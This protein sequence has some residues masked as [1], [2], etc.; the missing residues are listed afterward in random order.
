MGLQ[1]HEAVDDM[2]AGFLEHAR[3]MD[4]V[5]LVETGLQLHE[6]DHLLAVL[7][8]VDER[9]DDGGV[10]AGAVERHLDGQHQRVGRGS[11]DE[12]DDTVE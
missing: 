6:G 7:R 1:S 9:L 10:A 12:L 4:I 2:G 8:G 5:G 3:P 11:L